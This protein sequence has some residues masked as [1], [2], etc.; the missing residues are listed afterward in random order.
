MSTPTQTRRPLATTLRTLAQLGIGL[1]AS[2]AV[3]VQALGLDDKAAWVAGSLAVAAA[4]TRLMAVPQ[5]EA[6]LAKVAPWLSAAGRDDPEAGHVDLLYVLCL[7][8][9]VIVVIYLVG[10]LI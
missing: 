1:A 6:L 8:I 7:A 9:V 4:V 3:I 2:W 10:A 5:V